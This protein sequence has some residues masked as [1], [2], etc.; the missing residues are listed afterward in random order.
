MSARNCETWSISNE[1]EPALDNTIRE[2]VQELNG[3]QIGGLT[4]IR[5]SEKSVRE[6][7]AEKATANDQGL[8]LRRLDYELRRCD[9]TS[10]ENRRLQNPNA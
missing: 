7:L 1:C 3:F 5:A 4:A 9:A 10:K 8:G 6:M 2:A